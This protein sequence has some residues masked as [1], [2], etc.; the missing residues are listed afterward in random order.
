MKRNNL[1]MLA[2]IIFIFAACWL[3]PFWEYSLWNKFV[4]AVTVTSFFLTISD[5]LY[6][7][8]RASDEIMKFELKYIN[9]VEPEFA[10]MKKSLEDYL[11]LGL[12]E[13][14]DCIINNIKI[15]EQSFE[16]MR[17]YSNEIFERSKKCKNMANIITVLGFLSFFLIIA[18]EQITFL[19]IN[20]LDSITVSA[21]GFVLLTQYLSEEKRNDFFKDMEKCIEHKNAMI[22]LRRYCEQ[23]VLHNAD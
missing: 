23:E 15:L 16:D 5:L 2:Y 9:E 12:F 14:K 6:S 19:I 17:N 18:I 7:L 10:L 1:F 20:S 22:V 8:T 4:A 13:N 3:K 11:E 21:F